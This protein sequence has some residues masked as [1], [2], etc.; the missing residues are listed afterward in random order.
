M[1][2]ITRHQRTFDVLERSIK[3]IELYKNMNTSKIDVSDITS[4]QAAKKIA[5]LVKH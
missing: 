4:F 2:D 3:R 1:K 5:G